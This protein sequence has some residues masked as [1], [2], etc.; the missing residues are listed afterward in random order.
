MT[1]E[2]LINQ[3]HTELEAYKAARD[4]TWNKMKEEHG[5]IAHALG[6]AENVPA[7]IKSR[8]DSQIAKYNKEWPMYTGERHRALTDKHDKHARP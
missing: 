1:L 8:F 5:Q 2:E 6:G 7:E 3:Q 4:I